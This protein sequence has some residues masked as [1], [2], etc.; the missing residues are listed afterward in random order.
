MQ[1]TGRSMLVAALSLQMVVGCKFLKKPGAEDAGT[2]ATTDDAAVAEAVADDAAVAAPTGTDTASGGTPSLSADAKA[3]NEDDVA[4]FSNETK[5]DNVPASIL[6]ATANVRM[7]P[8]FGTIFATLKKGTEVKQIAQR[9]KYYLVTFN[10]PKDASRRVMG[11]T[12]TDAFTAQAVS[13]AGVNQLS[14]TCTGNQQPLIS[15]NAMFCG[16]VC[17][18]DKE[19]PVNHACKGSALLLGKDKKTSQVQTCAAVHTPTPIDAGAPAP[20]V[21]A[22]SPQVDAGAPK[23]DAGAPAAATGNEVKPNGTTCPANYLLVPRDGM[24]HRQCNAG[25]SSVGL[26]GADRCTAKCGTATPVCAKATLC[27]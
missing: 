26:C 16:I 27:P 2:A 10:D 12:H 5:L 21:D 15:D 8:P 13:D 22:G 24:C 18:V 9:D 1:K 14:I 17:K 6:A 23:V 25:V 7:S 19:C 4:R 11:W 20:K 3:A